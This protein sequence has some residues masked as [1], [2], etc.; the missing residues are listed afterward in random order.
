MGIQ[1]FCFADDQLIQLVLEESLV[2][3]RALTLLTVFAA[4]L[5]AAWRR[6]HAAIAGGVA[7]CGALRHSTVS[8]DQTAVLPFCASTDGRLTCKSTHGGPLAQ[9]EKLF[10]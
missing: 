3:I 6:Q 10:C 8:F 5:V 7:L 4:L 1:D 2:F 9:L